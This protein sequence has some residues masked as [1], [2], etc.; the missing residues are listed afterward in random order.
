MKE[1]FADIYEKERWGKG[2]GSGPG[3]SLFSNKKYIPFLE[4]FLRDNNITSVID[5]G[6][7]IGSLV[8]ILIGAI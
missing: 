7:E 2:R 5:F 1:I 3:S 8:S 6:A 4:N